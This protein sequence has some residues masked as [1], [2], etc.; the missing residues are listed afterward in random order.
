MHAEPSPSRPRKAPSFEG[1][2]AFAQDL[3]RIPSLSGQEE[4]LARRVVDEMEA[5][6]YDEAYIDALGSPVGLIRVPGGN[7]RN[8]RARPG[9]AP[10]VMLSAHADMVAEGDWEEW[11]H[12][13]FAGVVADGWLH[14]RGAMDIKGPLAI[15]THVGAALRGRLPCDLIVAHP[16]FEERGGW[17]MDHLTRLDGGE[18]ALPGGALPG[19]VIIGESTNGDIAVGHRGRAE[20]EVEAHGRAGHASAPDR[21][22]NALDAVPAILAGVE[23]LARRQERDPVLGPASVVAT[24][25]HATPASLNVIP[26]RVVVTLDWRILPGDTEE[27]LLAR[28]QREVEAAVAPRDD[29]DWNFGFRLAKERQRAWTGVEEERR[30]LSPGFL[31]DPDHPVVVAAARAVGARNAPE[32]PARVRPW[33]FATDGGWTCGVRGIPT[34]GFA[35]G[36]ERH[37]HTNRERLELA[38]ARWAYDRYLALVPAVADA[39]REA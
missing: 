22:A 9:P 4:A 24:G 1:A 31:V 20:I 2:V 28:V 19:A 27:S 7:D 33:T 38:K 3:I 36:L 39:L 23:G 30:I 18:G 8:G 17:G 25:I 16:V 35:P 12:P 34:I 15:Q 11:E 29:R 37:A 21:A 5:L 26:D 13:P 14:G 10:P 6:G 32:E